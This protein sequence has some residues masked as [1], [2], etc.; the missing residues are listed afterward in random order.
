MRSFLCGRSRLTSARS[1][2]SGP[3]PLNPRMAARVA[4]AWLRI[5]ADAVISARGWSGS[6]AAVRTGRSVTALW[7]WPA[8]LLTAREPPPYL[9]LEFVKVSR[10]FSFFYA[11][12]LCSLQFGSLLDNLRTQQQGVVLGVHLVSA[13]PEL[14][15]WG[16]LTASSSGV[17][18]AF[19]SSKPHSLRST[20][21][22]LEAVILA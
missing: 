5:H 2:T 8:P 11:P 1:V 3:V 18:L 17:M 21:V 6:R 15:V 16:L 7:V 10:S 14:Q 4:G 20:T 12:R 9:R 19:F 13:P 22:Y